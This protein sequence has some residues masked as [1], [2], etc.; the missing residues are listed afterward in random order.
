M[1]RKA[2]QGDDKNIKTVRWQEILRLV[3]KEEIG[4]QQELARRLNEE[5]YEVT[6]ATVSRDI[7][8]LKLFKTAKAG[9]GYRYISTSASV[10]GKGKDRFAALFKTAALSAECAL[11]QVVIKCENGMANAVCAAMDL[12]E[13]DRVVGSIAG[14]DTILIICRSES[15]AKKLA[16]KL[17]EIMG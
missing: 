13:W 11:N 12:L 6:Q 7:K 5:G 15:S 8:E 16:K 17:T 4:T 14:D 9:G 2:H 10:I 3:E 1:A